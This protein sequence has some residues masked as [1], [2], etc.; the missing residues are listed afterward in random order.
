[1]DQADEGVVSLPGEPLILEVPA[2]DDIFKS[3]NKWGNELL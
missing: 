3:S 2:T 1:M